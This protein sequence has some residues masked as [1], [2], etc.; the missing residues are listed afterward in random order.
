[1]ASDIKTELIIQY[2]SNP[3]TE[4]SQIFCENLTRELDVLEIKNGLV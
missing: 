4:D 2:L 3:R 1:M